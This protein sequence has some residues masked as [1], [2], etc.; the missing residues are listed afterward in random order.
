MRT[1]QG[2]LPP[3]A[4]AQYF[5]AVDRGDAM[6]VLACFTGGARYAVPAAGQE[7]HAPRRLVEGEAALS[8]YFTERGVRG[9]VHEVGI[10]VVDGAD[11][12]LEGRMLDRRD[13]APVGTFAAS[14]QLGDGGRIAR[15]L[16]YACLPSEE[17]W[18]GDPGDHV[19]VDGAALAARYFHALDTGAFE[20][21]AACFSVDT[22]YSHP[23]YRHTGITRPGR[24]AFRGRDELLEGFRTRGRQSFGHRIVAAGQR[25][26]H[27]LFEGV[28]E[29]LPGNGT[30][31][32]I[33]TLTIGDDGCVARYLS[34]VSQPAVPR[35]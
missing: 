21:A 4:V 14:I 12:L 17:A 29:G 33:S 13:G 24:I 27:H 25:G 15:Y 10:C 16:A 18:A 2:D 26:R 1:P 20:E 32:F 28:V 22:L 3:D 6:A 9:H 7:E 23:P 5:E 11:C 31:S 19:N 8:A 35:C 34:F 30:A